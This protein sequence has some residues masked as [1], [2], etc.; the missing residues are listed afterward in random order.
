MIAVRPLAAGD[1]ERWLPLWR[2][3]QRFYRVD[4]AEAVTDGTWARL[5]DPAEPVGGALA[6]DGDA[7]V[8]LVHRVRHRSTWTAGDYL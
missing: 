1:R 3:Y 8:G 6:L 2:G 7:A 4:I 5:L